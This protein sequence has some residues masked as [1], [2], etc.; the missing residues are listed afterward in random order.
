[1]MTG[2]YLD[3]QR[4]P[5]AV[6]I[7]RMQVTDLPL[8]RHLVEEA[9]WNQVDP[10]WAR[11]MAL[12]PEGCFVAEKDGAGMATTTCCRFGTVG[13]IAMVLVDKKARGMGIARRLV[14]YAV[15]YLESLGV[16]TIRLDATHM[17]QGLYRQ[18]GF[19]E[20]Y[21]VVRYAGI[22]SAA[23]GEAW[24]G[25]VPANHPLITEVA[26]L[27][28]K[29]TGTDRLSFL[30]S[31]AGKAPFYYKMSGSGSLDGYLGF[32]EGRLAVQLG[33]AAALTDDSGLKL[34][35]RAVS[36]FRNRKCFTDIPSPNKTAI[37]WAEANGF[38]EQ[39]N[40]VRMCRGEKITD[41]PGQIWASSGPEKG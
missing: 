5:P 26:A 21:M 16:R 29:I 38:T 27:D 39:R 25:R 18:L 9:G 30:T 31:L 6:L 37:R 11:A 33:P 35:D 8:C 20:E 1:M 14:A 28:R 13:W 32:R 3:D 10:D 34:L 41:H 2:T 22:P 23:G 36:G 19:Y 17:G 40:F 12:E 24:P 15:G 7:R 4:T